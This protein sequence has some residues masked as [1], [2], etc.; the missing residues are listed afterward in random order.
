MAQASNAAALYEMCFA[1]RFDRS[2]PGQRLGTMS[3][4]FQGLAGSLL[5]SVQYRLRYGTKF[6]FSGECGADPRGGF[7]C[8]ACGGG[9]ESCQENG[10]TF[11][12]VWLGGD[13]LELINDTTGLFAENPAGGRDRLAAG[14]G[15]RSFTLK[16]AGAAD[17]A[18]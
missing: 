4:Y 9:V 14:G 1:G 7:L 15:N 10:E 17:C 2:H 3:V 11:R 6:G 13:D 18:W 16:R 5:T 8:N 12:I